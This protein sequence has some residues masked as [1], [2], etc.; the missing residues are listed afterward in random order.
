[1]LSNSNDKSG[2]TVRKGTKKSKIKFPT[3][4]MHSQ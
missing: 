4:Q 1:L 2:A 3:F